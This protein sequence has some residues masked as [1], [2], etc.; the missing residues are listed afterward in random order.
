MTHDPVMI[1]CAPQLP[2]SLPIYSKGRDP[3]SCRPFVSP[4]VLLLPLLDHE[5]SACH[6]SVDGPL[7][8]PALQVGLHRLLQRPCVQLRVGLGQ[9][10]QDLAG[11][12][13]GEG[14]GVGVRVVD[15]L[16]DVA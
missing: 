13:G 4:P 15:V 14:V 7:A 6:E 8:V 3:T 2:P 12:E 10:R 9:D 16:G 11:G 5:S 1:G